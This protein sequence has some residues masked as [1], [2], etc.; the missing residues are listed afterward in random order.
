M[1]YEVVEQHIQ[2]KTG[3]ISDCE[4]LIIKNKNFLG[5]VDGVTSKASKTYDGVTSGKLTA[6][7]IQKITEVCS[8]DIEAADFLKIANTNIQQLYEQYHISELV[9]KQKHF[10]FG[11]TF[12][13]LNKKRKELW[14]LGDCKLL[15][16]QEEQQN[17]K[18]IDTIIAEI[19]RLFIQSFI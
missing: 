5:I 8:P 15:I 6:L 1:S 16:D 9:Q 19:R 4:D 14:I 17:N 11:A 3:N 2:S 10:R 7:V 12:I 13:L 18:K